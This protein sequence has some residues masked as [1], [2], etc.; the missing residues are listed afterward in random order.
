MYND[1][2]GSGPDPNALPKPQV[3][4]IVDGNQIFK[5]G[6]KTVFIEAGGGQEAGSAVD[7]TGII[8]GSYCSC[9][10]V[11]TC[12][13]VDGHGFCA[14]DAVCGCNAQCGCESYCTCDAQCA[15]ENVCSCESYCSCQSYSTGGGGTVLCT[16]PCACV[17]VH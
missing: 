14:C 16:A 12:Q 1:R 13:A 6:M 11:C 10:T 8:T 17:P 5:P 2:T 9:D 15:C 4:I 7:R 3:S